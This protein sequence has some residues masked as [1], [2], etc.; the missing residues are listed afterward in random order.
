MLLYGATLTVALKTPTFARMTQT[1]TAPVALGLM[2]L[3]MVCWGSWANTYKLAGPA[4]FELFYWDYALGLAAAAVL[5]A[6]ASGGN[7]MADAAGRALAQAAA[8]GCVF[9]LANLLLVAAIAQAGLAVA[10]PLGIGTALIAGTALTYAVDPKGDVSHLVGGVL[11]AALAVGCCAIA[12]RAQAGQPQVTRKGVLLCVVS[13]ILMASWSPLAAA[14]MNGTSGALAPLGSL[15][16][17]AL[18]ALLSTVPF[19]LYFMRR[20]L[21]GTPLSWRDYPRLAPRVHWLGLAGGAIWTVGTASNLVAGRAVGFA[22]AYAIGQS[23]PLV[24]SLWGLF[25]W[26]EFA[27]AGAKV[28][29]ALLAMYVFYA[30]AILILAH[31]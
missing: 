3:S 29:T 1:L 23:A 7:G 13:G 14:S 4:R 30:A 17:F 11:L 31:A 9:N 5:L 22:V 12:Y 26:R 19:N 10:F 18:A 16:I 6:V 2:I 27:G 21:A 24:A 28:V 15:M 20:P 8:A 25:V